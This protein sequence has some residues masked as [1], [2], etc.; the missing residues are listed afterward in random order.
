MIHVNAEIYNNT[1]KEKREMEKII[2]HWKKRFKF[3]FHEMTI[4]H[5]AT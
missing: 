4:V 5:N 2:F 1:R 3:L